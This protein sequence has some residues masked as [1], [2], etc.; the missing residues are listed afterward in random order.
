MIYS[1]TFPIIISFN[2]TIYIE[3]II[4]SLEEEIIGYNISFLF[5]IHCFLSRC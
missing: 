2:S 1:A 5:S 4:P 3:D